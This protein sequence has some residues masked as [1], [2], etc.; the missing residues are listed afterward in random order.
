[1]APRHAIV[2]PGLAH[3]H[4]GQ[5]LRI[6]MHHQPQAAHDPL[7]RANRD[8]TFVPFRD[9]AR[10]HA[11]PRPLYHKPILRIDAGRTDACLQPAVKFTQIV[12]FW[13]I[14]QVRHIAHQSMA[15]HQVCRG[16]RLPAA[17]QI[18]LA[19]I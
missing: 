10:Q 19:G 3:P 1:M 8:E 7:F 6:L 4:A 18:F 2:Q 5:V 12:E 13:R 17:I 15:F 16:H 11:N 9:K 14:E